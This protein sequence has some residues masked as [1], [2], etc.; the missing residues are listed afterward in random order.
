MRLFVR[1]L[2]CA[3]LA[4]LIAPAIAGAAPISSSASF[5]R[6]QA[7]ATAS[8]CDCCPRTCGGNQ[9]FGCYNTINMPPDAVTCTYMTSGGQEVSCVSCMMTS[10]V[11]EPAFFEKT[12][13]H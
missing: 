3:V 6:F 10:K 4:A 11:A 7:L 9:L 13:E 8:I 2:S 5:L 1:L 12:A